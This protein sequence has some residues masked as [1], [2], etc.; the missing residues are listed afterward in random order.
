[1]KNPMQAALLK[2]ARRAQKKQMRKATAAVQRALRN[3]PNVPSPTAAVPKWRVVD[4]NSESSPWQRERGATDSLPG[5]FIC[6]TF[7]GRTGARNYKLYLPSRYLAD[8]ENKA[9]SALPLLVMLHG[10]K[11]NPDDFAAG[12]GMNRVAEERGFFV[13][14]PEQC[15][16]ANSMG[17]WNWFEQRDQQRDR[18]EPS[19]LADMTRDILRSYPIDVRRMWVAGLSAGGAMALILAATHPD[20]FSA[21]GVHSGLAYGAAQDLPHAYVAMQKGAQRTPRLKPSGALA[22]RL[23]RLIV[24]HGDQDSTVHPR[25]AAQ[26]VDQWLTLIPADQRATLQE[27][28]VRERTSSGRTFERTRLIDPAT[29]QALIERWMVHGGGHAWS[30]GSSSGSYTE[31]SGPNASQAMIEFFWS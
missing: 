8:R 20:L 10:C 16:S 5:R 31:P 22:D 9:Q 15:S 28:T 6:G 27:S 13:L 2:A 24:F 11:Q 7:S 18:G 26:I 14:Y 30:G 25:N 1:M 17:C 3:L 29:H 12:T 4:P 23:P 19:I 21:V